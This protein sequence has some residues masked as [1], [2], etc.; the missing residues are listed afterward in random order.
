[1]KALYG[2]PD[3]AL[4]DMGDFAGGMLKYLRKNP[5]PRVS[6][7]GGFAKLAKLGQGFLDLHSGRSQV[8]FKWLAERVEQVTGDAALA[9]KARTSNTAL[10]VLQMVGERGTDLAQEIANAAR[11]TALE[12]LRDA[13][14]E[15]DIVVVD[16]QGRILARSADDG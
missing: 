3:E 6:I 5:V 15:I 14:C 11:L 10:E 1:M 9:A 7:A 2:L 8:D 16:R 12:T 4:L 13:P